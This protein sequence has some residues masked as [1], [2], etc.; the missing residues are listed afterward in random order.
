MSDP[1]FEAVVGKRKKRGSGDPFFDSVM[2]TKKKKKKDEDDTGTSGVDLKDYKDKDGNVD[3]EKLAADIY[4]QKE[5]QGKLKEDERKQAEESAKK[6][7]EENKP[8]QS[9]WDKVKDTF[10]ANTEADKYRREQ[11]G[12]PREWADNKDKGHKN[13][14]EYLGDR[15][16][17]NSPQDKFIR[18]KRGELE[19]Y[20]AQKAAET[21]LSTRLKNYNL[22]KDEIDD[23]EEL[24]AREGIPIRKLA[25]NKDKYKDIMEFARTGKGNVDWKKSL[26]QANKDGLFDNNEEAK[27]IYEDVMSG[28][29]SEK[30]AKLLARSALAQVFD[31][32]KLENVENAWQK[33]YSA[34]TKEANT[35][36]VVDRRLGR[37]VKELQGIP[38]DVQQVLST[39]GAAAGGVVSKD[40]LLYN[41][42][43]ERQIDA[44]KDFDQRQ[45][46][47]Q[48]TGLGQYQEDGLAGDLSAGA[49]SLGTAMMLGGST[50]AIKG[51]SMLSKVKNGLSLGRAGTLFGLKE[52]SG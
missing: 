46:K 27:K 2:S 13:V 37:E 34:R 50:K 30:G 25:E 40:N 35:L 31:P 8:N 43:K 17:K 6:K 4:K 14:M 26:E 33:D 29:A 38:N 52:S 1:Y 22:A 39:V 18:K 41:Y 10:D 42:S 9:I 21:D 24:Y 51:A 5:E 11:E 12:K 49:V 7:A 32:E 15:F 19:D 28:N 3:T 20:D 36:E 47:L 16:E 44:Q 23:R 45:Q 48:D